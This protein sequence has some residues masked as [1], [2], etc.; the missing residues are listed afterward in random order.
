[1][2]IK[3]K[4]VTNIAHMN[5]NYILTGDKMQEKIDPCTFF[6]ALAH[7]ATVEAPLSGA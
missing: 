4:A 6:P 1:M 2:V 5:K 7:W 3:S